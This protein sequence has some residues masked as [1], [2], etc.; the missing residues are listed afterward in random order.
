MARL[1]LY[2]GRMPVMWLVQK[3][4]GPEETYTSRIALVSDSMQQQNTAKIEK[5][6]KTRLGK[7]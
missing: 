1:H 3:T 2:D 5:Q 4:L 7:V 6:K